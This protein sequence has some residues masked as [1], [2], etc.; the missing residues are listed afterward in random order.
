M[1]DDFQS[2]ERLTATKLNRA[3]RSGRCIGRARRIT[4]SPSSSSTT[5]VPILRL[6]DIPLTA[7]RLYVVMT[8]EWAIDT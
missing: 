7:G 2:H 1:S 8:S 4:D 3:L 5:L 6:D